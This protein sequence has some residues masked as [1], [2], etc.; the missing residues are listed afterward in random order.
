MTAN[1]R[2]ERREAAVILLLVLPL[3]LALAFVTF[4]CFRLFNA[5][6]GSMAPNIPVGTH[7]VVSRLSYGFTRTTFDWFD[8]PLAE[9]WPK[10]EIKRG[11]ILT[12]RKPK[13]R[14]V[15]YLKRV[16]GLPGDRVQMQEGRLILN[17]EAVAREDAGQV[18]DPSRDWQRTVPSYFENLPGGPRYKVIE[19]DGDSGV[20]D[21]TAEY[22]VPDNAIFLLGD[23]R[24]N[25]SD[26]RDIS[27]GGVGFVPLDHINGKVVLTF[28]PPT[29][30]VPEKTPD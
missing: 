26:S 3:L 18:P 21:N 4:G 7:F 16:I 11:D 24:D 25:S 27:A 1:R 2:E 13:D 8:L 22:A 19:A 20:F 14:T 12:F 5:P 23:N 29:F 9:R 10:G 17:G 30:L 15:L 6:S 28:L